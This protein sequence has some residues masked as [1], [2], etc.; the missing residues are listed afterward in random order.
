VLYRA[1]ARAQ[2]CEILPQHLALEARRPGLRR[3]RDLRAFDAR[4]LL[5]SHAGNVSAAAR[6]ASMPRTSFRAL[7][8]RGELQASRSSAASG[9]G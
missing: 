4:S 9:K 6:A 8:V 5:E 1:A 3:V 2:G 7:L